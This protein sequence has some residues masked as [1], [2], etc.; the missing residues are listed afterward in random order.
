VEKEETLMSEA[1]KIDW[2]KELIDGKAVA[3]SP[4]A[5]NHNRI[6][7]NIYFLF[8]TYLKGKTC[9]PYGDN[10]AVFLTPKDKFV[11]D[12]MIVCDRS[13]IKLNGIHGAPDLV[14]EILSP[15]TAKND[16]GHKKEVYAQCG[17]LEYWIVNPADMSVEVYLNDGQGRFI[18]SNVYTLCPDWMLEDMNHTEREAIATHFKC[19]LYDDLDISLDDIFYDLL[20]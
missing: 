4:A 16:R 13:K 18:L 15:S 3:M 20:S 6:A 5:N 10:E 1:Y 8:R 7:G 2:K 17:V 14:V 19:S 11:P 9:V 12:F